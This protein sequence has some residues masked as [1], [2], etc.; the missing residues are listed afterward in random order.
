LGLVSVWAAPRHSAGI[1]SIEFSFVWRTVEALV[2]LPYSLY[3]SIKL[4]DQVIDAV[5]SQL[6]SQNGTSPRIN[7]GRLT[8]LALSLHMRVDEFHKRI[9]K[10]IADAAS[11]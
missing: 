11:V 1:C 9:A 8:Y 6:Q 10:R 4:V 5:K 2:G 7:A 3:G